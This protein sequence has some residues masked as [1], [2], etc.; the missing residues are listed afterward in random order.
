M[1][2]HPTQPSSIVLEIP[3][4]PAII[5][6]KQ[7]NDDPDRKISE[8]KIEDPGES[9]LSS[10]IEADHLVNQQEVLDLDQACRDMTIRTARVPLPNKWI[11]ADTV[12][13]CTSLPNLRHPARAI[14]P[15][16]LKCQK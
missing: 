14:A 8:N 7:H 11:C 1:F 4:V 6:M 9:T 10:D 5:L 3:I 12:I 13:V 16:L 2:A 15:P